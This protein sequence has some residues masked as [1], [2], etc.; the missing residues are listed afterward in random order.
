MHYQVEDKG[1]FKM[2]HIIGN[3]TPDVS[4]KF[5]DDTISELIENGCHHFVFN[6]ERTTYLDSSGIGVFIH[7]LCD[8]QENEGSIYIIAEENQVRD[9]LRMVGIDRLIKVYQSEQLFLTDQKVVI[10]QP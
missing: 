1:K 3:L 8:V 6:L 5:I 9:V 4:T 2:I 7:C 10:N